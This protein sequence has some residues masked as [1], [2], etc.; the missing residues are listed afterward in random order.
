MSRG[1]TLPPI[2]ASV[3]AGMLSWARAVEAIV[4]ALPN[5]STIST[6]D[7]PNSSGLTGSL[8]DIAIDVGS[9]STRLWQKHS[10]STSTVGWNAFL[11][12]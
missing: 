4:L 2:P 6:S 1:R 8:G 7:G 11:W 10:A 12:S 3:P 9:S 5:V